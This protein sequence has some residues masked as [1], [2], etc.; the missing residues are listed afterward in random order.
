MPR[1]ILKRRVTVNIWNNPLVHRN[2]KLS[3]EFMSEQ[4]Q[5]GWQWGNIQY[6]PLVQNSIPVHSDGEQARF[7]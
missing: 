7:H 4:N 5:N 3:M 6:K 2:P 1:I